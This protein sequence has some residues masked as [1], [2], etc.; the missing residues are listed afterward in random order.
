MDDLASVKSWRAALTDKGVE[1]LRAFLEQLFNAKNPQRPSPAEAEQIW[2][3]IEA[4]KSY[5]PKRYSDLAFRKALVAVGGDF[6]EAAA[7]A[8]PCGACGDPILQPAHWCKA[9]HKVV[10]NTVVCDK[11]IVG[12]EDGDLFCNESCRAARHTLAPTSAPFPRAHLLL[13]LP[14]LGR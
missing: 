6:L 12:D 11:V 13:P 9:C 8:Q 3:D 5:F 1:E 4:D 7:G 2:Q 14:C 10:H